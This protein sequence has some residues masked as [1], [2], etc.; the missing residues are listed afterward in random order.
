MF[1]IHK[2]KGVFNT[3]FTTNSKGLRDKEYDYRKP[4]GVQRILIL[5]DSFTWGFGVNDDEIYTEILESMLDSTE[6]INFGVTGFNI[7]QEFLYLKKE[8]IKY[9][10]DIVI[11]GLALNDFFDKDLLDSLRNAHF[12]RNI[13]KTATAISE[14]SNLIGT[15]LS[16]IKVYFTNNSFLYNFIIERI[17]TNKKL[18]KL[19]VKFGLKDDLQGL[20][21]LDRNLMPALNYYSPKLTRSFKKNKKTLLEI[22][23][24]LNKKG[25]R[26]IICIIPAIE[27]INKKAFKH[28]I[29]YT[30]F[31]EK[32][33]N[34][35]KPYIILKN[36]CESN[37]IEF[38][39]PY[40]TFKKKQ[41]ESNNLYL[42]N[43]MHFSKFGHKLLA[44]EIYK[45]LTQS[46]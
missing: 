27:T 25:V 23:N 41:A 40:I 22:R 11:V 37:H 13:N 3:R 6:V 43:D 14:K 42:K 34:L 31:E 32:D 4:P 2:K 46:K 15:Q 8:G 9:E 17:N 7:A 29:A 26:F 10:P 16:N 38:I 19:L 20:V 30:K 44:Q 28:S 18:V 12:H 33:F 24:F 5:G 35:E 21:D 39:N 36:F 1:G 45:F